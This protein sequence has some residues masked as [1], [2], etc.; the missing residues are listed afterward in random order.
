MKNTTHILHDGIRGIPC[1]PNS[2]KGFPNLS[3]GSSAKFEQ[4]QEEDILAS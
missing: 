3:G 2:N 1:G 4:E